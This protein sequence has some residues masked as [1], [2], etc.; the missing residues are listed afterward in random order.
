MFS[1]CFL[2]LLIFKSNLREGESITVYEERGREEYESC[3]S[4]GVA[5]KNEVVHSS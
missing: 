3:E 4:I 5:N 1:F 2:L